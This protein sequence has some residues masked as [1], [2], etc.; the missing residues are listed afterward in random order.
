MLPAGISSEG[1]P[2]RGR[3][4]DINNKL[5][6]LLEGITPA[7][8]GKSPEFRLPYLQSEDHPRVGGEKR[9]RRCHSIRESGSPPR[10]RG[11]DPEAISQTSTGGITPA[12]AGKRLSRPAGFA[13]TRDHPRVGGEK[14]ALVL[15]E[16]P[17]PGSPP[18]GR[19]KVCA[20]LPGSGQGRIT[21][22]W[23]GKSFT[24]V[25]VW[26]CAADHPRVGGEKGLTPR[27]R[28]RATGSPPRGRG[29]VC[30]PPHTA[31]Y[32]RITPAWAGK[33][34]GLASTCPSSRDHPRVGGEKSRATV[35]V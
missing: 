5:A 26:H 31:S 1:S 18:R 12:W 3:G 21:P 35:W 19:G 29:K 32:D 14:A 8:A 2:P 30:N 22:A 20:H 6:A 17:A 24:V 4:K 34:H 23:A 11:K 13:E 15:L 33:S 10:G 9:C 27:P 25:A 7:W 16:Q 28:T